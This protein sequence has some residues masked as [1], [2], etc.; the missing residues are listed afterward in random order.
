[1]K[2]DALAWAARSVEIANTLIVEEM[3]QNFKKLVSQ[4]NDK[5]LRDKYVTARHG[6]TAV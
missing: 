3:I 4:P 1:M 6:S 5:R 2:F